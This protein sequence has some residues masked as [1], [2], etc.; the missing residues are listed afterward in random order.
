MSVA[1]S[2]RPRALRCAWQFPQSPRR[3]DRA[4][5]DRTPSTESLCAG[6]YSFV[7]FLI[8]NGRNQVRGNW[9]EMRRLHR[10]TGAT[11]GK[12]TNGSRVA[13]QFSERNLGVND[14][15]VT[16]R[17][18]TIDA[19]TTA[20]QV[21]ADVPL[22]IFRGDVFHFH[23]WLEQNRFALFKPVFQREDRR[24]LKC[25]LVRIDFVKR[26][27]NDID[28]NI[29][30]RITAQHAVKHGFLDAFFYGR[31]VFARNDAADDFVFDN[32]PGASSAGT[33]IYFDV[34]VL[35]AA[36]RLFD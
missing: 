20:A 10:I 9:L 29:D 31:N 25:E 1:E 11:L 24:H 36:T 3:I 6:H 14:G 8:E 12:R 35:T 26:T 18:D 21:A 16:A 28:F 34:A 33:D 13:E 17:L 23:D 30:N 5:G 32:Q 19:S 4:C 2:V 27:V 7:L 15:E 22:K